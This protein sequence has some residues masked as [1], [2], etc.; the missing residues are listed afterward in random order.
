MLPHRMYAFKM[1]LEHSIHECDA[2][3]CRLLFPSAS[4]CVQSKLISVIMLQTL[5]NIAINHSIH[6]MPI[7]LLTARKWSS[8]HGFD[9][10]IEK[11]LRK[12]AKSFLST[13]LS[14]AIAVAVA[15]VSTIVRLNLNSKRNCWH[16]ALFAFQLFLFRL[17]FFS[18]FFSNLHSNI[19]NGCPFFSIC[20]LFA[21][22]YNLKN[23]NSRKKQTHKLIWIPCK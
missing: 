13:S 19:V 14:F 4:R 10:K 11:K 6:N 17:V 8:N 16:S 7:R 23:E 1:K 9:W 12:S 5:L 22:I 15:V 20:N 2:Q 18:S 21:A 3:F